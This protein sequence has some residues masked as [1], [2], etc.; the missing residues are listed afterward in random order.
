MPLIPNAPFRGH[1]ARLAS[2]S[3]SSGRAAMRLQAVAAT[4]AD[5]DAQLPSR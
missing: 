1:S 3:G 4:L 5:L 2:P